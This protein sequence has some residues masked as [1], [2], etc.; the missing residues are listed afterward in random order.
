MTAEEAIKILDEKIF[1]EATRGMTLEERL[2][3]LFSANIVAIAA[4]HA[5]LD[6]ENP[7]PDG[8]APEDLVRVVRCAHCRWWHQEC[9][10]GYCNHPKCDTMRV[11]RPDFY[12][13]AGEAAIKEEKQY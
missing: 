10:V 2:W 6:R 9:H 7:Q 12:C 8:S 5:Q 13:A 3:A 1:R 4:L 11:T